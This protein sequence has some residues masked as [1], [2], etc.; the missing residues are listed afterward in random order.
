[1]WVQTQEIMQS[2][3]EGQLDSQMQGQLTSL[4]ASTTSCLQTAQ[5]VQTASGQAAAVDQAYVADALLTQGLQT[6]NESGVDGENVTTSTADAAAS[7]DAAG[8]AAGVAAAGGVLAATQATSIN[9]VL[10]ENEAT[11]QALADAAASGDAEAVAALGQE[12]L[13]PAYSDLLTSSQSCYTDATASAGL[14]ASTDAGSAGSSAAAPQDSAAMLTSALEAL[15]VGRPA[16]SGL[17]PH[18]LH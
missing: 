18:L 13:P 12:S 16:K 6:Y 14:I 4:Q 8:A 2:V 11:T 17:S 10:A 9:T 3:M 1:M 5:V 15:G 7:G